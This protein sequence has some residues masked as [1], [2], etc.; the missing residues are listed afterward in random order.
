MNN[1]T[2]TTTTITTATTNNNIKRYCLY[3]TLSFNRI[4]GN[5]TL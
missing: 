1:R 2:T 3:Q 5:K 4:E